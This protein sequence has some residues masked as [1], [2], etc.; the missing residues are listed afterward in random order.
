MANEIETVSNFFSVSYEPSKISIDN[1]SELKSQIK[2]Y[3]KKY[4]KL[5]ATDES[6]SSAKSARAELNKLIKAIDVRRKAI[7]AE[8]NEPYNKFKSDVD[9]L[10]SILQ[11]TVDPISE[12]ITKIEDQRRS[13]R[14]MN[15]RN[16]I[17]KMAPEYDVDPESIEIEHKWTNKGMTSMQLTKILKDGFTAIKNRQNILETNKRLIDE[18]CKLNGLDSAGWISQINEDTDINQLISKIDKSVQDRKNTEITK[19]HQQEYE[20]AVKKAT[21][22][23]VNDKTVDQDTGEI[24]DDDEPIDDDAEPQFSL[25]IEV[26]DNL[27]NLTALNDYLESHSLNYKIIENVKEVGI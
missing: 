3:A 1:F 26:I 15:V 13:E 18:H 4:K 19:K 11:D 24:V 22:T 21:Q 10:Q 8:Y 25:K 9:D 23:Q 14:A 17:N 5:V 2:D 20:E 16:L 27:D 12:Q 6:L 7:K